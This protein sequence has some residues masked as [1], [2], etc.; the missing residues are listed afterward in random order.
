M[1]IL[2]SDQFQ[3]SGIRNSGPTMSGLS[4]VEVNG[5]QSL[6]CGAWASLVAEHKLWRV[7]APVLVACGLQSSSSVVAADGL[8]CPVAGGIFPDQELN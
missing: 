7:W 5:G 4:Q 6:V 1:Q 2:L 3:A 8:S